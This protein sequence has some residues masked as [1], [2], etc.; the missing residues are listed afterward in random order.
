VAAINA[1]SPVDMTNCVKNVVAPTKRRL[2]AVVPVTPAKKPETPVTPAVTATVTATS[3]TSWRSQTGSKTS[4]DDLYTSDIASGKCLMNARII[5]LTND[6]VYGK[7]TTNITAGSIATWRALSNAYTNAGTTE[8]ITAWTSFKGKII[9]TSAATVK[10]AATTPAASTT[11]ATTPAASTTA[12]AKRRLQAPVSTTPQLKTASTGI[13]L[14]ANYSNTSLTVP[15][16]MAKDE[17]QTQ[18][19]SGKIA[20]F[21]AIAAFA[22]LF[23]N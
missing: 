17:S 5:T 10:A 1:I 9:V 22:M 2:Q 8:I 13:S 4:T 6:L 16:D 21:S 11:A 15:K 14:K 23:F 20:M 3:W 7:S 12:P 19:A 18:M